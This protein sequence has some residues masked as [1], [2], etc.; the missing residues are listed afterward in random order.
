MCRWGRFSQ[1]QSQIWMIFR[2]LKV[3]HITC[4]MC[5]CDLP[6]TVNREIFVYENIHVLNIHVNKFSRVPHKNILT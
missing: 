4:N 5:A 1:R 2:L 6:D 3:I